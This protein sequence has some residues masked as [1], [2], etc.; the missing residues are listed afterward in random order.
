[1]RVP[2]ALVEGNLTQ[3]IDAEL[4]HLWPVEGFSQSP[5]NCECGERQSAGEKPATAKQT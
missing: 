1:M 3:R 5:A 2:G 4:G